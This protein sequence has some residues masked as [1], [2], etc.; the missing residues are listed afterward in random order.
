MCG[1]HVDICLSVSLSHSLFSM[2]HLCCSFQYQA[3]NTSFCSELKFHLCLL[4]FSHISTLLFIVQKTVKHLLYI[5]WSWTLCLAFDFGSNWCLF[6]TNESYKVSPVSCCKKTESR[7]YL[8]LGN[9]KNNVKLIVHVTC[10]SY[11]SLIFILIIIKVFP[12]E[13]LNLVWSETNCCYLPVC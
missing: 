9:W 5:K 7:I 4:S 3:S 11:F 12:N 6:D 1:E 13:H 8:E 10:F 2:S